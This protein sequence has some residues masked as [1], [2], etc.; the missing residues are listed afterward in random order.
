MGLS[1]VLQSEERDHSAQTR[2]ADI[3]GDEI[4][5]ARGGGPVRVQVHFLVVV[6]FGWGVHVPSCSSQQLGRPSTPIISPEKFNPLTEIR[7]RLIFCA[8]PP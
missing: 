4:K 6:L 1:Y 7:R 2:A 3:M 8:G 5:E